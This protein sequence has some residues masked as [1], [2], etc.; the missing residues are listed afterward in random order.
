MHHSISHY[1]AQ[2]RIARL[3]H[4]AQHDALTRATRRLGRRRRPGLRPSVLR[5][6][7]AVPDTAREVQPAAAGEAPTG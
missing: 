5:R 7:W 4:Q 3:R 6:T 2:A 1:M